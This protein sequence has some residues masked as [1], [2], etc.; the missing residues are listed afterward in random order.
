MS[1]ASQASKR[2]FHSKMNVDIGEMGNMAY[3]YL[4]TSLLYIF[5]IDEIVMDDDTIR[6]VRAHMTMLRY[7]GATDELIF[8]LTDSIIKSN[9]EAIEIF[10]PEDIRT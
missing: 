4:K 7:V 3:L 9:P 8:D 2:E 10:Y 1:N 5:K 6:D